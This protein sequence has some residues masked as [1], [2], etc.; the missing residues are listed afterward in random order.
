MSMQQAE[1]FIKGLQDLGDSYRADVDGYTA[2]YKEVIVGAAQE[3]Q[4]ASH[5]Y[6]ADMASRADQLVHDVKALYDQIYPTGDPNPTPPDTGGG[7]GGGSG[8][9][10][11]EGKPSDPHPSTGPAPIPEPKGKKK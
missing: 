4:D 6:T 3:F 1:D 5:Q 9:G 2:E 8:E 11:W 7:E 10:I